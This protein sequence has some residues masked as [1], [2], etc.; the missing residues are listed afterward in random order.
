MG[1]PSAMCCVLF[2]LSALF[3]SFDLAPAPAP[4]PVLFLLV[5]ALLCCLFCS[6]LLFCFAVACY[7]LSPVGVH[8]ITITIHNL[9]PSPSTFLIFNNS[10]SV[11]SSR[12]AHLL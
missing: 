10:F 2:L 7:L 11:L 1:A 5:F 9:N 6:V 8:P 12:H 3:C 4:A